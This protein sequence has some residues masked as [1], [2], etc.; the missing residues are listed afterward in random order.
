[1]QQQT[2]LALN[3]AAWFFVGKSD[4]TSS[5]G[6]VPI[7]P[8]FSIGRK[9][10]CDLCL[11]C[12]SVSGLHAEIVEDNEALW[13]N[14]L[15]STNG[16]F[17]N[18]VRIMQRTRLKENDTVQFGT[19]VFHITRDSNR[20]AN[21]LEAGI[22]QKQRFERL[23]GGGVVPFF[24]SIV[25]ISSP[26][27]ETVGY[28][29]LGRSRLFG[30]QTPAEMFAAAS[31]LE[32]EAELSRVLRKRGIKIADENLPK[33]HVLFVNTHP[34]ELECSGLEDSLYEI[35]DQHPD[36]PIMMEV[37]ESMLNSRRIEQI[38]LTLQNLDIQLAF[39][40]FGSGQV[41]IAEICDASL[42]V[43]KFD[44]KL[45]QGI[46]AATSK[47][48][49]FVASMV[50]M[51]KE[52]GVKPMAERVEHPD[53]HE[54]LK[55]L[56]FEYGQGFLYG[57][58]SSISDCLDR[59]L[60]CPAQSECLQVP[61]V[62]SFLPDSGP[63]PATTGKHSKNEDWLMSQ[64]GHYYTVQV[65]SAISE[66]RAQQHIARQQNPD[67]FAVFCKQGKTRMLYIVVFGIFEDRSAAK[68]ASAKLANAAVSP[69]IRMLSSVQAEIRG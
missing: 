34:A 3:A 36:R 51:V 57:R 22:P 20:A 66:E 63:V 13:V 33:G 53:E 4:G 58:P 19:S 40:D 14:D 64:P 21:E 9:P 49:H 56:G 15:N 61:S 16:T 25:R 12:S 38:R 31:Q 5:V 65:L 48:Q 18:G 67:Q 2:R 30:L 52:L 37:H 10:G 8:P 35:R 6:D 54:T 46:H 11:P 69:W 17:V 47:R 24:Q 42:D 43:V 27:D 44:V 26:N 1:M 41:S 59:S 55:Q 68:A 29:V 45:T 62:K 7:Q 60:R 28:E 23:L 39:H 32:M 50:K